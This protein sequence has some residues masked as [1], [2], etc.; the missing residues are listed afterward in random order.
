MEYSNFTESSYFI[1]SG[2]YVLKAAMLVSLQVLIQ[3][4][5]VKRAALFNPNC[6]R[7]SCF[8]YFATDSLSSTLSLSLFSLLLFSSPV[9]LFSLL[10]LTTWTLHPRRAHRY[11]TSAITLFLK[12]QHAF[13]HKWDSMNL[14]PTQY[15]LTG[16]GE[17]INSFIHSFIQYNSFWTTINL[18]TVD[19]L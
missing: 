12:N 17:H 6:S 16:E 7:V 8:F 14:Y 2:Y 3:A 15:S 5:W 1:G 9:Y 4:F 10:S 18:Y 11:S 19:I 13:V